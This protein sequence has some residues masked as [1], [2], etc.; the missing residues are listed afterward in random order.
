MNKTKD[1]LLKDFGGDNE[2]ILPLPLQD[3]AY[4]EPTELSKTKQ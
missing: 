3:K 1:L 4:V 2:D